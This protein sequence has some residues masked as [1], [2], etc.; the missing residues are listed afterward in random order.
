MELDDVAEKARRNL[1]MVSTGILAVWA[2][3]IPL[4]G[5]LVGAV[6]LATVAPWRAWLCVT[7][8]LAYFATRY[9]YA[10]EIEKAWKPWASRR[11]AH[12][13]NAMSGALNY[14]TSAE[15][16]RKPPR[17]VTIDWPKRPGEAAYPVV[18]SHPP[19]RRRRSQFEF[20]WD[21][22]EMYKSLSSNHPDLVDTSNYPSPDQTA[23]F[24][25]HWRFYAHTQWQAFRHA[26]K[27]SWELLEL[28]VP[29]AVASAAAIVCLCKLAVSIYYSWP[30]AREL[31]SA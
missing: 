26:Y 7:V 23:K 14:Q 8:V 21:V 24:R 30:F 13:E 4:D 25:F 3:G 15:F 12:L 2:L 10:P 5:K 29:W 20:Y 31:L 9:Y 1:M 27:L 18:A 28:S 16:F 6:N 19:L 22:P 17:F 11:R